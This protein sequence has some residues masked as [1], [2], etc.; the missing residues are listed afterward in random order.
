R[1]TVR[2]ADGIYEQRVFLDLAALQQIRQHL[3]Q[4]RVDRRRVRRAQYLRA[5]LVKLPVTPLLRPLPPKHWPNVIELLIP[6]S[7]LQPTL[8]V[9]P[10]NRRRPFR[11]QRQRLTE[12]YAVIDKQEIRY[13]RKERFI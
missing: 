9:C 5:N 11:P 6:R 12:A 8:D 7:H 1:A 10:H 3:D 2:A 4:L 13:Q